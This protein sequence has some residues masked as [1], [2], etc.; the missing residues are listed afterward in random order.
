[1]DIKDFARQMKARQRELD[2]LLRRTLPV[3]AG[4]MA[5]DHFQEGFRRGGFINGGLQPWPVTRRQLSGSKAAS[6]NYGPLLSRRNHLFSSIYYTPSDYRVRVGTGVPYAALHNEG[7]TTHPTVTPKM[8][9]FAWAMAYKAAGIRRSGKGRK[10]GKGR[11]KSPSARMEANPEALMWKRLALTRK[12]K[13]AVRIPQRRFLGESRELNGK[14]EK[15]IE[16][17]IRNI[18]NS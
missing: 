4:R 15:L 5:K 7:G 10:Q 1:M 12:K 3:K 9:R 8:R 6:A 2:K 11:G 18:L 13:L 16:K 14:I 17:E